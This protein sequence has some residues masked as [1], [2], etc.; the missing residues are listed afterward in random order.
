MIGLRIENKMGFLTSNGITLHYDTVGVGPAVC[1]INGY[2]LSAD[3]WPAAFVGQLAERLTVITFDNRGTGRSDKPHIGY[4]FTNLAKDVVELLDGLGHP[5]VHL[6]GYS[7]GGA[8][9]QEIAIHHPD[10]V[11]RL[12]L[13]GTFCGGVW[14]EPASYSVFKRFLARKNQTPDEAARQAWP[15]T[16]SPDYL[17]ANPDAVERQMRREMEYPTPTFVAERQMEALRKFDSY[18]E[19]PRIRAPTL[20]A[21]GAHDLLVKPRNSEILASR[22]RNARREVLADLGHRAIWEAPEEI[23][24]LVGDFLTRP[25]TGMSGGPR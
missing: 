16:Y 19:L 18:R 24:D 8:I 4:E 17:A 1:L 6:F 23:A 15:F 3:A 2:R 7:M 10:R 14:A 22:I 11:D 9:A 13:F 21:T 5:Q 25:V 20:V 12:V